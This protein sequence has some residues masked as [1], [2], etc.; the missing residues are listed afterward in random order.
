MKSK[1]RTTRSSSAKVTLKKAHSFLSLQWK[2]LLAQGLRDDNWELDW[3]SLGANPRSQ[4]IKARIYAKSEGIWVGSSLCHAAE[5][6]SFELGAPLKVKSLKSD[7]EHLTAGMVVAEWE[8]PAQ[9]LLAIER[10]FLNIASYLGGI[11]LKTNRLVTLVEDAWKNHPQH[12]SLK[13]CPRVTSTRKILPH[14]RDLAIYA[15][16]AGGGYSH[17][18]NLAGGVLIKENHIAAAGGI[19]KAIDGVKRVMPHGLKIEIEVRNQKELKQAVQAGAEIVMLDNFSPAQVTEAL[20]DLDQYCEP[21]LRPLIEISGGL[22]ELTISDYVQ[23]G[24][25]ILSVGS[26]THS[27]Q[28]IDLSLIVK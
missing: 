24:V 23:N 6:L 1:S 2:E 25:D 11:A 19:A 21:A 17:R 26:L 5:V 15:V 9:T 7:G 28:S 10:P 27:V 22:S 12:T 18:V 13:D 16:I 14:Y 3:T 8:G 20:K 4:K